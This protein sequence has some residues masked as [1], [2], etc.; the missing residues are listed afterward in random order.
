METGESKQEE[1]S[2]P[3]PEGA[4]T[5]GPAPTGDAGQ[6]LVEE[7]G[8]LSKRF[9]EAVEVAWNS[10]QRKEIEQD[11]RSGLT[12]IAE[13]LEHGLHDLSERKKTKQFVGKAEDVAETVTEKI[14][15]SEKTH[16]LA[17]GLAAGLAAVSDRLEQFIHDLQTR[18]SQSP[19]DK[20]ADSQTPPAESS[21]DIPIERQ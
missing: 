7:L 1:T 15:S 5:K 13:S 18:P 14:R 4:E 19:S 9:V 3:N 10:D 20:P 11:L 17:A 12:A 2:T 21:Q 6:E 8:R 16:E